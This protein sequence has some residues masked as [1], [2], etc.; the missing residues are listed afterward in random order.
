M[1]MKM[2]SK[3]AIPAAKATTTSRPYHSA[4]LVPIAGDVTRD[5]AKVAET[6]P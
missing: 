3:R 5:A 1:R 4:T 2:T 6:N